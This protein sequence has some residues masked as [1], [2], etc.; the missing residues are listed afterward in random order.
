MGFCLTCTKLDFTI[1]TIKCL[2]ITDS[3]KKKI[4]KINK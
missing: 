3:K 4:N 1:Y 2:K